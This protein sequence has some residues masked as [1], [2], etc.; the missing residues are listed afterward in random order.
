VFL[1]L[2]DIQNDRLSLSSFIYLFTH[3]NRKIKKVQNL[4]EQEEERKK[5]LILNK[6]QFYLFLHNIVGDI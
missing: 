6:F 1:D 3:K 2:I 5:Q 4:K